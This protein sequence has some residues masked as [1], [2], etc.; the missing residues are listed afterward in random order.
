M[1]SKAQQASSVF[2]SLFPRFA[3][4]LGILAAITSI[5][6]ITRKVAEFFDTVKQRSDEA[7]RNLQQVR[8]AFTDIFEALGAFDEKS[9]QAVTKEAYQLLQ[10]TGAPEAIGLPIINAYI[11]QFENLVDAGQITQQQ[12]QQ[13]MET[14][15][16]YG[17]RHSRAATPQLIE[18]MGGW[19]IAQ[20]EQQ[21]A[22]TRQI[23]AA[24]QGVR[25]SDEQLIESLSRGMP[26]IK[27]MGWT[28]EQALEAVATMAAGEP[29]PRMRV[30][31]P[32][33]GLQAIMAP[34]AEKLA[35]AEVAAAQ[36]A[37]SAADKAKAEAARTKTLAAKRAADQAI[38][39]AETLA[40]DPL[41]S[42][43]RSNRNAPQ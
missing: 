17:T 27:A 36:Q 19:G 32:T 4:P 21:A 8:T 26:T 20:P 15:L 2:S 42:Y 35:Y 3:G 18:L 37:K 34:Q 7:V 24:S 5:V 25:L 10:K 40:E 39:A 1:G 14:M 12:Y 16:S 23:A 30:A 9:R 22:F 33:A 41:P 6:H 29:S 11:R 43:K 13:G 31:L 28:P 38:A